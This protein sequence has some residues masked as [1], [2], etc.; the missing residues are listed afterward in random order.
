MHEPLALPYAR[1]AGSNRTR[2]PSCGVAS[3]VSGELIFRELADQNVAMLH[4][5]ENR[6]ME[7]LRTTVRYRVIY[8]HFS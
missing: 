8:Y 7:F 1:L 5:A 3:P 6:R 2:A 4:G